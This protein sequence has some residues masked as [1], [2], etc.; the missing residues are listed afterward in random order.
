MNEDGSKFT[1]A[2]PTD[3]WTIKPGWRRL[4]RAQ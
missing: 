3:G 1:I 4:H 2:I